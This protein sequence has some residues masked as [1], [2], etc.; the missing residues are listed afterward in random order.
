MVAGGALRGDLRD[1]AYSLILFEEFHQ[2]LHGHEL[3][4][5]VAF[6]CPGAVGGWLELSRPA[7]RPAT[8]FLGCLRSRRLLRRQ[9]RHHRRPPRA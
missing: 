1:R 6:S 3:W 7:R 8:A 5:L 2:L 9:R 4:I